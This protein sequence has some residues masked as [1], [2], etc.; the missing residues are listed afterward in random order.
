[1]LIGIPTFAKFYCSRYRSRDISPLL[2]S[3]VV[4]VARRSLSDGNARAGRYRTRLL[5]QM[6][7]SYYAA[8]H[9][10]IPLALLEML[11]LWS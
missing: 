10:K 7:A 9:Q 2:S 11:H 3:A 4:R 1:M 8:V 5:R 6:P